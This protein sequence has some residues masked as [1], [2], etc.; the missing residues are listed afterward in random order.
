MLNLHFNTDS[1]PDNAT[2]HKV[3]LKIKNAGV[4]GTGPFLTHGRLVADICKGFFG[5]P[6]LQASDFQ[7]LATKN[8][9]GYFREV[10]G[11]PG[12]Y[13]LV[14]A[15]DDCMNINL[16]GGT[17]FRLRFAIDDNNDRGADFVAFYAGDAT[18]VANRPV[19]I[20]ECS[21]P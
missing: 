18:T 9:V 15:P 4:V 11:A 12:W 21:I 5:T 17:Q 7:A 1:L 19:L 2:I 20:V 8:D 16:T 3:T 10:G 6:A 13:R 14:L